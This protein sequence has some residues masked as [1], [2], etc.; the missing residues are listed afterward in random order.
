MVAHV[1]R[2]LPSRPPFRKV[3]MTTSPFQAYAHLKET[4]VGYLETAYKISDTNVFAERRRL[5]EATGAICQ[6]AFLETTP[7]YP[8]GRFLRELAAAHPDRLPLQLV[9]LL[10]FGT[11]LSQKPFWIHQDRAIEQWCGDRPNLV[12]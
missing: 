10:G 5:L 2:R 8:S 4:L 1:I 6:E 11:L 9:E 12:V 7:G 3:L